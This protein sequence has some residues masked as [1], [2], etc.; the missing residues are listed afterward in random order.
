MTRFLKVFTVLFTLYAS[1]ASVA[2][3]RL[4]K[5]GITAEQQITCD[6]RIYSGKDA[7]RAATAADYKI[8]HKSN[9]NYPFQAY[10]NGEHTNLYPLQKGSAFTGKTYSGKDYVVLN[11]NNEAIAAV[12]FPGGGVMYDCSVGT[13]Q[14]QEWG[15]LNFDPNQDSA[16]RQAYGQATAWGSEIFDYPGSQW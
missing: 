14:Q 12:V 11:G 8:R 16:S 1:S 4:S 13:P 6:E 9:Y 5:R 10:W 3:H 2:V 7:G 15:S